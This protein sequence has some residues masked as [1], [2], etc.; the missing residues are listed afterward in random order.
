M[1]TAKNI[2]IFIFLII[3]SKILFFLRKL[4]AEILMVVFTLRQLNG[5]T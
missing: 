3:L 2:N 5:V 1:I 4:K